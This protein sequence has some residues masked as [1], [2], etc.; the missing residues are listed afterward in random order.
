MHR[1]IHS[2]R[3]EK[4]PGQTRMKVHLSPVSLHVPPGSPEAGQEGHS[5]MPTRCPFPHPS[6]ESSFTAKGPDLQEMACAHLEPTEPVPA[7]CAK[8]SLVNQLPIC[9][10]G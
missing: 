4:R 9:L 1:Q 7:S 3:H 10:I 5:L 2:L 8:K 6:E